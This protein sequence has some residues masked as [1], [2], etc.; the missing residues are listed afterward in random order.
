MNFLFTLSCFCYESKNVQVY[1]NLIS[2]LLKEDPK[3]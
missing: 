2:L 3:K 1:L